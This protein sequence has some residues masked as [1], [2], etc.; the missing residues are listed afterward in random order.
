[1]IRDIDGLTYV[2]CGD[3]VESCTA[4]VE[5]FDGQLEIIEWSKRPAAT[6]PPRASAGGEVP[7]QVSDVLP[8]PE[9]ARLAKSTS[10]VNG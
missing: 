1:M 7:V 2:N 8:L 6:E 5:H 10:K 9:I 3:W 4:A